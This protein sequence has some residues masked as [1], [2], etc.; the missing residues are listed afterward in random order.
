[1]QKSPKPTN[2]QNKKPV[3]QHPTPWPWFLCLRIRILTDVYVT[4]CFP[5]SYPNSCG[6]LGSG[7]HRSGQP[8][9]ALRSD[10][11]KSAWRRKKKRPRETIESRSAVSAGCWGILLR[12]FLSFV[13]FEMWFVGSFRV[14][15]KTSWGILFF[16]GFALARGCLELDQKCPEQWE[17]KW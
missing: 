17:K 5:G 16:V 10:V 14:L 9:K 2:S 4:F 11:S 6:C 15:N 3:K 8:P 7:P 12:V 13:C 1:M